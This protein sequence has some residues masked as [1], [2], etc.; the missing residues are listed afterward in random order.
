M[1]KHRNR[2]KFM[3]GRMTPEEVH[4]EMLPVGAKCQGCGG[5]PIV[6][7]TMFAE[8]AEILKRMPALLILREVDP[9]KYQSIRMVNR[10]GAFLRTSMAYACHRCEKK[11]DKVAAKHPSWALCVI[12]RGPG[13]DKIVVG[14]TS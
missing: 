3:D 9:E 8:E 2:K 13:P 12:D 14:P 7:Y 4:S 1:N 11:A 6:K 5:A 10:H